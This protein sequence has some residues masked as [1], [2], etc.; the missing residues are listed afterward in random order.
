MHEFMG[1]CG[2]QLILHAQY[3]ANLRNWRRTTCTW[4]HSTVQY[5]EQSWNIIA[6]HPFSM[7]FSAKELGHELF[8][9]TPSLRFVFREF[10]LSINSTISQATAE[11]SG[12]NKHYW[13]SYGWLNLGPIFRCNCLKKNGTMNYSSINLPLLRFPSILLMHQ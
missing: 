13:L 8:I 7:S 2:P 6:L 4:R 3:M 9:D 5:T 11:V 12:L 10:H 1:Q